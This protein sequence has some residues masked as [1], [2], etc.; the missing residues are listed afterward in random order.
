MGRCHI[1]LLIVH[2]RNM[3][4]SII[5]AVVFAVC[6]SP[7]TGES[8]E[9]CVCGVEG[10]TGGGGGQ[11]GVPRSKYPWVA[12]FKHKNTSIGGCGAVLISSR[13][14]VTAAHCLLVLNPESIVL[15]AHDVSKG[16]DEPHRKAVVIEDTFT[17]PQFGIQDKMYPYN[18]IAL[19]YLAEE[20]DLNIHTPAC[21]PHSGRDYTGETGSVYGWRVTEICSTEIDPVLQE[22][23][24]DVISDDACRKAS[25]MHT[26]LEDGVCV[27][28]QT[29]YSSMIHEE[30][31]CATASEQGICQGNAGGP[32]T[33]KEHGKHSLVGVSSW[34]LGCGE[35]PSVFV[36]VAHPRI[37]TWIEDTI[38]KNGGAKYCPN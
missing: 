11:D 24:L 14:A 8:D 29:S 9:E 19:L 32:F 35:L 7:V 25:A 1:I 38:A 10:N 5:V 4:I 18:N 21:L 2:T 22:V 23:N 6:M 26:M 33:V 36:E 37:R 31:L 3:N 28:N 27:Q 34:V 16:S 13:W 30:M 15:G 12:V 17:Y 20:I